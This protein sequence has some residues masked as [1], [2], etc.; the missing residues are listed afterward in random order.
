M[1]ILASFTDSGV[2]A[3]GISPLPTIRI[4]D[5]ATSS[6]VVTDVSM[7]ETGDGFYAYDFSAQDV[8]KD[9]TFRCDAGDSLSNTERY[10]FG[11]SGPYDESIDDIQTVVNST[12]TVVT[13]TD[14]R[15]ELLR[16]FQ[17]NRLELTDGDT[18]NWVLYNDDDTPLLSF[19]VSDKDGKFII[20]TPHTP[21][22]RTKAEYV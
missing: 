1:W 18:Y 14:V 9:Y 6:L 15:T 2:P 5:V 12:A 21:S 20:Q 4:R 7:A 13:E 11:S 10:T 19:A 16:K 22:K 3:S 8:E 17:T